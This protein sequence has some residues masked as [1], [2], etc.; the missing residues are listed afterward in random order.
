MSIEELTRDLEKLENIVK[1]LYLPKHL[2]EM[3]K[4]VGK[5]ETNV[6]SSND[7][8]QY[9]FYFMLFFVIIVLI[10]I[11]IFIYGLYQN[12]KN[13][14]IRKHFQ[15]EVSAIKNEAKPR[16]LTRSKSI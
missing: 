1:D 16:K 3:M 5:M 2:Q 7:L 10:M 14:L 11:S 12:Y 8:V 6:N 9:C 4:K 15:Y 13:F